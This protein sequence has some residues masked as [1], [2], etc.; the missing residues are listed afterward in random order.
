MIY[1]LVIINI[2]DPGTKR[3]VHFTNF[4]SLSHVP[5]HVCIFD[6]ALDDAL[7]GGRKK[8]LF[9]LDVEADVAIDAQDQ[10]P[11]P[12]KGE[13]LLSILFVRDVPANQKN[14]NPDL[15][16]ALSKGNNWRRGEGWIGPRE[17]TLKFLAERLGTIHAVAA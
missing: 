4:M 13:P 5:R 3:P 8:E 17:L 16:R 14:P 1:F 2:N 11:P 15:F 6:D 7:A 10:M 12:E 9:V